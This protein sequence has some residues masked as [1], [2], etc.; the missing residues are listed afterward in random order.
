MTTQST[1]KSPIFPVDTANPAVLIAVATG[2]TVQQIFTA[3][4]DGGVVTELSATNADTSN[5]AIIQISLNDGV[6][7]FLV[8]E[9][10]VPANSGTDGGTT[11]SHNLFDAALLPILDADGAFILEASH[12]LEVNAKVAVLADVTIV[13]VGGNY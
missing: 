9:I 4:T 5:A 1:N 2:T 7:S 8:G 10:S 6:S 13:G 12:T 3:S 11:T